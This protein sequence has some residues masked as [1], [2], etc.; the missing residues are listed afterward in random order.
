MMESKEAALTVILEKVQA[1]FGTQLQG[2][3]L[4]GSRAQGNH[5]PDSDYDLL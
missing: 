2:I 4:Y 5:R 3:L 1:H